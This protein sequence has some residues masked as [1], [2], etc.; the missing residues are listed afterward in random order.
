MSHRRVV[1]FGYG[2]LAVTA[3]ETLA[4]LGVTPA[5]LVVPGNRQASEDV[6][7]AREYARSINIPV[8]VQPLR[9][10]IAPFLDQIKP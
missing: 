5:A 6:R 1:V 4:K 3:L 10:R 2:P 7:I 8:L 9:S